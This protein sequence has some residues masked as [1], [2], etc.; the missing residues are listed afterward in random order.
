[1]RLSSYKWYR[2]LLKGNWYQNRYILKEGV[3]VKWERKGYKFKSSKKVFTLNIEEYKKSFQSH[4]AQ[5]D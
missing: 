3:K 1:M 4:N 2:K 5:K